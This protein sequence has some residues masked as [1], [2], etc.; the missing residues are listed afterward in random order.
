MQDIN[1]GQNIAN[2]K[3]VNENSLGYTGYSGTFNGSSVKFADEAFK[4]LKKNLTTA[5]ITE[6]AI[7]AHVLD[8]GEIYVCVG[9]TH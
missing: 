4:S 3:L 6:I 8:N 5:K 9:E 7:G 2:L 1:A